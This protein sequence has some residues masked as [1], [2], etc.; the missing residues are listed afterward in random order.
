MI[1]QYKHSKKTTRQNPAAL[2]WGWNSNRDVCSKL[3]GVQK[4]YLGLWS[5]RTN[6]AR[7]TTQQN[8]ETLSWEW[9][10]ERE[11]HT[12]SLYRVSKMSTWVFRTNIARKQHSQILGHYCGNGTDIV[13]HTASLYR[14][15][16]TSTWVFDPLE[17]T[18]QEKQLS[19]NLGSYPGIR[20]EIQMPIANY[21]NNILSCAPLCS[22]EN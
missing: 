9:N 8:S 17:L 20:A 11:M 21:Y 6:I 22:Y 1:L 15:P 2:S 18:Y 14:V 16:K 13:M 19:K 3:L 10:R 5:S 7:K 4:I 12:A